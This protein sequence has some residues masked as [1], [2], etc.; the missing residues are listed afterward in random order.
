MS[1]VSI[2]VNRSYF[3]ASAVAAAVGPR[4]SAWPALILGA[5][6]TLIIAGS[7]VTHSAILAFGSIPVFVVGV[8]WNALR[9]PTLA[10][11]LYFTYTALE[12]MFKYMSNSSQA[13]YVVKPFLLM[14]LVLG[15][16]MSN[17][18]GGKRAYTP[19]FAALVGLFALW[20]LFGAVNPQASGIVP[21]ILTALIWYILPLAMYF[22]GYDAFRSYTRMLPLLYTIIAVCTVVAAFAFIQYNMG[23]P[24][25]VANVPGYKNLSY[26]MWGGTD[27]SGVEIKSFRP[28]ST[29]ASEGFATVWA[30]TGVILSLGILMMPKTSLRVKLALAAT[31]LINFAG[32]LTCG[33]R[34]FVVIG[35]I[36]V[37]L[38]LLLSSN[39]MKAAGRNILILLFVAGIVGIGV[40]AAQSISNGAIVSRYAETLANPLEKFSKDRG[41]FE[42]QGGWFIQFLTDHPLGIGYQRGTGS[43]EDNKDHVVANRETQFAAVSGDLGL[44]GLLLFVGI[45]VAILV[46][47]FRRYRSLKT[48]TYRMLGTLLFV[49]LIGSS[50]SFWGG[51]LIV[52]EGDYIWFFAGLLFM[53][54]GLEK[55]EAANRSA[56]RL[57]NSVNAE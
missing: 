6:M 27:A 5:F 52:V 20:S 45:V 57:L 18:A 21:G 9:N 35:I 55:Q 7:V 54:P 19:P 56:N 29:T 39:S 34:L 28:A 26:A 47:G 44:P 24:W 1:Q 33:V 43:W 15:W 50:I 49:M 12:G 16:L 42:G 10:L 38:L 11:S 48:P 46:T 51:S 30:H 13:I 2:P 23:R 3:P 8:V 31:M 14:A 36:E 41:G 25:T 4:A 40:N 37:V 53:L 17:H 32:L 22:I